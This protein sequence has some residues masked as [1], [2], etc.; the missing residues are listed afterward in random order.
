MNCHESEKLR[1]ILIWIG[2]A[3]QLTATRFDRL[4]SESNLP[5][6][7]F[8]MLNHFSRNPA[9]S[10]TVTQLASAFQANQPAMTKTVQHL[11]EK[12]YLE[13]QVSQEDKRVKFHSI[14]AAGLAAHQQAISQIEPDAQ[15]IFA[16]WNSD[17][18]DV[19]HQSLFRL[20]NWLDDRRDTVASSK[21]EV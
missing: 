14:T 19:L 1:Q 6:P 4:M 13:F 2:V 11:L 15:L 8:T 3:N 12:G 10:Y 18:I 7:Q 9:Q 21:R 5:L 16:E 17:E 20:K